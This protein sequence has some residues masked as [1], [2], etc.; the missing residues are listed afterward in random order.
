MSQ[1][2]PKSGAAGT[3]RTPGG[4]AIRNKP[5]MIYLH[6]NEELYDAGAGAS[7]L[8][9]LGSLEGF[10]D[11]RARAPACPLSRQERARLTVFSATD[12]V[13]LLLPAACGSGP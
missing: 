11:V 6:K 1:G 9:N 7:L 13:F 4:T 3:P 10:H 2:T 8:V 5:I 12:R